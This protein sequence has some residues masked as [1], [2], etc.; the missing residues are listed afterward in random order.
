MI[1]E[2]LKGHDL[3]RTLAAAQFESTLY[4]FDG[5]KKAAPMDVYTAFSVAERAIAKLQYAQTMVNVK[6][7]VDVLGERLS[8][9]EAIKRVGGASRAEKMWR[10][11]AGEKDK[12]Q[13]YS[14]GESDDAGTVRKAGETR[15]I[16]TIAPESAVAQAQL[17]AKYTSALRVAIAGANAQEVEIEGLD[18]ALFA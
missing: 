9:C 5:E 7:M 6:V 2:A 1:R 8:L 15:A 3:K 4:A 14:Y 12:K 13:R 17:V 16:A 11:A 18:P 10:K